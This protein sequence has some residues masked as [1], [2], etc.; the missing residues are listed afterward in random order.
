MVKIFFRMW[1]TYG[2]K[3]GGG[4]MNLLPLPPPLPPTHLRP[5]R[6]NSFVRDVN[7]IIHTLLSSPPLHRNIIGQIIHVQSH[8]YVSKIHGKILS[9]NFLHIKFKLKG[10]VSR[11]RETALMLV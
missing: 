3:A 11:N 1:N 5:P 6:C 7:I 8:K 9:C 2:G 4:W 10:P